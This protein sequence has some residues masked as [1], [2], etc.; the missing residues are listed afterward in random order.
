MDAVYIVYAQF[1]TVIVSTVKVEKFL[2][3]PRVEKER[4]ARKRTSSNPTGGRCTRSS[5]RSTRRPRCFAT[6]ADSF[7][8]EYGARMTAMQLATNNAEEIIQ[9]LTMTRNRLRQAVI[10]KELAEIV[11]GAEVSEDSNGNPVGP[12]V[13][14]PA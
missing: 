14:G 10:T 1:K 2:S 3:I 4:A 6:L 7:A 13:F 8:S 5:S 12:T 11:G 9:D